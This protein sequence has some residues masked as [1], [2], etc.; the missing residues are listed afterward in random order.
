V[1]DRLPEVPV[2]V[3]G[4]VPVAAVVLA[5]NVK[6]LEPMVLAGLNVGITPLGRP[7]TDK[8]TLPLKPFRGV[9]VTV[10]VAFVPCVTLK[11]FG[12]AASAKF[13]AGKM[14][15]TLSN[16]AVVSLVLSLLLMAKPT[17]T[18]GAMVTVWLEP[19]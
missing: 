10:L 9:T 12:E 4:K 6:V 18:F 14:M 8:L 16:V 15:D 19:T 7:D 13:G 2:I 17:K 1:F 3:S 5:V 11:L